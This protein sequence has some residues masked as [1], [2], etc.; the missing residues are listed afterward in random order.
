MNGA[1][2]LGGM[3]G[4]GPVVVEPEGPPFRAAWERRAHAM[5]IAMG[6][7]GHWNI[8]ASRYARE[9][10]PPG[11]YLTSAY[12]E[13]WIKALERLLV[14]HGLVSADELA[15]RQ[16]LR[17]GAELR[18]VLHP[19]DVRAMLAAR[20]PY[21]RPVEAAARYAVGDRVRTRNMHPT[22]HTR[23][24]RYARAKTGVI[25]RLHGAHV[26]PDSNAHGAGEHPEWLYSV[27]FAATELWGDDGDPSLSVSIDAW[28][29]YLQAP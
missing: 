3:M 24:P 25:E 13:I 22:G 28:E 20:R 7:A 27:R 21:E 10:L 15:S 6:A 5:V 1:A 4:F 23:L 11:E 16:S 12:Y 17:P 29:S 26:L 14:A 8:D 18:R 19:D 2:D 9:S